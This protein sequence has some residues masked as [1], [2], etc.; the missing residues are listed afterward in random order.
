MKKLPLKLKKKVEMMIIDD[1]TTLTIRETYPQ[2]PVPVIGVMRARMRREG[3][4]FH[5]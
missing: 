3:K 2:V 4:L 5:L 1:Q